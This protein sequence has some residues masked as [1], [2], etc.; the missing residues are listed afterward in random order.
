MLH[1]AL[2]VVGK[3]LP[4]KIQNLP[5]QG[6]NKE[7]IITAVKRGDEDL[8]RRLLEENPGKSERRAKRSF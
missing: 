8:V 5:L 6:D 4:T 7:N 1:R 2:Q 3:L